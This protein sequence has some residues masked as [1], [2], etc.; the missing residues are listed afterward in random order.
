MKPLNATGRKPEPVQAKLLFLYI[1]AGASSYW[2]ITNFNQDLQTFSA[3]LPRRIP[4]YTV[5]PVLKW[6]N[7]DFNF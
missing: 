7:L 3:E 5:L 4:A 1:A 2:L 6:H